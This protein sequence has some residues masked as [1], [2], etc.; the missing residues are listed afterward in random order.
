[1]LFIEIKQLKARGLNPSQI[2]RQLKISRPTVYEYLSMSYEEAQAWVL[3]LNQRVKKLDAYEEWLVA[4]LKEFPHLSAAQIK[5]WLLERFPELKVG[6]STVRLYVA[7]LREKYQIPKQKFT[8]QY[9]AVPELPMGQQ[10]QVDW[11][12]TKQKTPDGRLVKLFVMCFVLA[13][14]R[15][16][17]MYWLDRPFQIPDVIE[18]HERAF[19]YFGGRTEEIVYDQD[20]LIAVDENAGDLIL[21]QAFQDYV[22]ERQFR[23]VL[24]RKADPETKGKIENVV[25]YIKQNFADSR[26]YVNLENWNERALAWLERTGN[27]RVH[28]S[29]KKRPEEVFALEKQYLI[30]IFPLPSFEST[31]TASISRNIRKDNTVVYQSNRYS[32][33]LGSYQSLPNNRVLVDI[34][35]EELHFIHPQT[36]ECIASHT[37]CYGKGQLIQKSTHQRD[38]S[39]Q[40][41]GLKQEVYQ[42]ITSDDIA[43]AFMDQVLTKYPRYR[44]DQLQI[45]HVLLEHNQ[46][47][48]LK[49]IHACYER[50]LWSANDVKNMAKHL[51][52]QETLRHQTHVARSNT[53][54]SPSRSH[55]DVP[56]RS[57]ATYTAIL[58]GREE[59]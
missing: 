54:P 12:E 10:L 36:L 23:V 8:R 40:I 55:Y 16:K 25:K 7:Q 48:T 57:M 47:L 6:D 34:S 51:E 56:V 28:E 15:Q 17:Y 24:C 3:G 20:R 46:L 18:G 4:W 19:H 21:T 5:D 37:V 44:R 41:E 13:R 2:A 14:S 39:K 45:I 35:E 59:V 1:M 53:S 49:A 29:T 50:Q 32:L 38:R 33:P 42:A 22:N 9:E 27:H 52:H 30:P 26:I 31:H 11:G 43:Q 58:E